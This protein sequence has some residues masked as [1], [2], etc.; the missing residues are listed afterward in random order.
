MDTFGQK[1]EK[2]VIVAMIFLTCL[3]MVVQDNK[4]ASAT[5]VLAWI[6]MVLGC[7][8]KNEKTQEP[9]CMDTS[10]AL[11][12][13]CA[14]EILLGHVGLLNHNPALFANRR[15]GILIVGVFFML[16]GYGLSYGYNRKEGYL[17]NFLVKRI[18]AILIP[19]LL[20]IFAD[21]MISILVFE[22]KYSSVYEFMGMSAA[23]W[24]IYE[25]IVLYILFYICS[26]FM[27]DKAYIPVLFI[28][29]LFVV[30]AYFL[31]VEEFY[32]GSTLCFPFGMLTYNFYEKNRN[33]SNNISPYTYI[34]IYNVLIVVLLGA[35]V[36]I[37][38]KCEGSFVGET[39][40]RNIAALCFCL[41]L[42][43]V[44]EHFA[45]K[46]KIVGWLGT[47]SLEIFL[48][49]QPVE[50]GLVNIGIYYKVSDYVFLIFVLALTVVFA[51]PLKYIN[52][53]IKKAVH[54]LT[55]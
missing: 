30:T 2:I 53:C 5:L 13:L 37:F 21:R 44:L 6:V 22:Q 48:L 17:K 52:D 43:F 47:L 20:V 18:S 40:A 50:H 46:G 54:K 41:L 4:W 38:F 27:N 19:S 33:I 10:M 7:I 35:S 31:K 1:R 3:G 34:Y 36:L 12:G 9:L 16:S 14:V 42:L 49:H 11:R 39:V 32:Y 26:L 45:L 51:I 23:T 8:N 29:V 15:A 25:L 28:S 55:D 24:Y